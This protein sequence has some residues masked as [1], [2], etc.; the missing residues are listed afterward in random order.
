MIERTL[1]HPVA[2]AHAVGAQP[3]AAVLLGEELV[4]WR[5]GEGAAHSLRGRDT[6]AAAQ[7]AS[8]RHF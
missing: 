7:G 6:S 5:D 2:L 8:Q 4:L 3:V 1:W